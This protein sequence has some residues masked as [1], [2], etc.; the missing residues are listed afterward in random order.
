MDNAFDMNTIGNRIRLLDDISQRKI[1]YSV[2]V[3]SL[4]DVVLELIKNALDAQAHNV[5]IALN[6]THG[7][8]SVLDDGH[9]I[10]AKEFEE[11]GGLGKPFH[12]S[13]LDR[14]FAVYGRH[15]QYLTT[16]SGLSLLSIASRV[17]DGDTHVLWLDDT[18][19][20]RHA[21]EPPDTL[22]LETGTRVKVYGLFSK[23]PV[24]S[25]AQL[26][27]F[28]NPSEI[29][30]EFDRLKH[31]VLGLILG[32]TIPFNI[33]IEHSS[34]RIVYR[35]R[36]SKERATSP[37]S[38]SVKSIPQVV[39]AFRQTGLV[40]ASSL[41]EWVDMSVESGDL[42]LRGLVSKLP[43]AHRSVQYIFL[44]HL[45]LSQ[46]AQPDL[47]NAINAAFEQSTFGSTRNTDAAEVGD[48]QRN[49]RPQSYIKGVDKWP[50]FAI[51]INTTSAYIH[52]LLGNKAT[53]S[54]AQRLLARSTSLVQSLIE[55]FLVAQAFENSQKKRPSRI[56]RGA[57]STGG[58]QVISENKARS[59]SNESFRHWSRVKSSRTS[60]M[61]NILTGLPFHEKSRYDSAEVL[62]TNRNS[63]PLVEDSDTT[64]LDSDNDTTTIPVIN[65]NG[66]GELERI[67]WTDP[68]TGRV[69]RLDPR[70]GM[71]LPNDPAAK[72]FRFDDDAGNE[73][74][75]VNYMGSRRR[76]MP[77]RQASENVSIARVARNVG[78]CSSDFASRIDGPIRS[79]ANFTYDGEDAKQCYSTHKEKVE[80]YW[81]GL[82]LTNHSM[83]LQTPNISKESLC[84]ARILR[85]VDQKFVLTVMRGCTYSDSPFRGLSSQLVLID[86]HAAD[87][88]CK[89]EAL[90]SSLHEDEGIQLASPITFEVSTKE[91]KLLELAGSYFARW[92]ILYELSANPRS[93]EDD[94][95]DM[96]HQIRITMLP[97]VIAERCRLHPRLI[98]DILREGI[99]SDTKTFATHKSPHDSGPHF[100]FPDIPMPPRLLNMINSRA[101]RS[102]IM[103]NDILTIE[104]CKRL[105]RQLSN[106]TLPFQ[107]AHGRPSMVV[108]TN[109]GSLNSHKPLAPALRE[110]K[111]YFETKDF[112]KPTRP[113]TT[114]PNHST[115]E[116]DS[117]SNDNT[118]QNDQSH[119]ATTLNTIDDINQSFGQAYH[120][121]IDSHTSTTTSGHHH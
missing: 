120:A 23:L 96:L 111:S 100:S 67:L 30:K 105:V 44:N 87:E 107:C 9:G 116:V 12:T 78:R 93:K 37:A 32:A 16:L 88:R 22:E 53:S 42:G 75:V 112:D 80:S 77:L 113:A 97:S 40:E 99:W 20:L 106:C 83:Q 15:G 121:W 52:D 108:L 49:R 7:F 103:F 29:Q 17:H 25:K 92:N 63:L 61:D 31:D 33:D 50:M 1:R 48:L 13:K 56:L 18:G 8:C 58:L 118:S 19:R 101:C 60:V 24:R 27:R 74:A 109:V 71:E 65:E 98:I 5:K 70:T 84:S 115:L 119:N 64:L 2:Q 54:P 4:N 79:I 11:N 39:S 95:R 28:A 55:E 38:L 36:P 46:H 102:A 6:Y 62:S 81:T 110:T 91:S 94:A 3:L 104:Q 114:R 43:I 57:P 85:Q 45:P 35:Y 69:L 68:Q 82:S 10:S 66:N 86:Q 90:L 59:Q 26:D 21:I 76:N 51:W 72:N 47:Y 41:H 34:P 73:S 14:T 89:V 117:G